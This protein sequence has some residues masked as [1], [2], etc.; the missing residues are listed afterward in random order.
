[1]SWIW[2]RAL[3]AVSSA[4]AKITAHA[5]RIAT[6][7]R[8]PMRPSHLTR[9]APPPSPHGLYL[10]RRGTR[11]AIGRTDGSHADAGASRLHAEYRC[12]AR[13]QRGVRTRPEREAEDAARV[14]RVDHAVV[15][16]PRG[17]MVRVALAL[18]LL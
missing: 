14:E 15:P 5:P 6:G 13:R 7:C 12:A 3:D 8:V 11:A 16:Q 10:G 9:S 17:R 2:S 18:V 4:S 1:V